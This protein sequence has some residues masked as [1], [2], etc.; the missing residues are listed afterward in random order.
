MKELDIFFESENIIGVDKPEGLPTTYRNV[1]DKS[2]CVTK[3]VAE[4]Y[5]ETVDKVNGHSDW[6]GGL[7]YR[8]DNDTSGIV[9]I[10]RNQKT[11][12]K[13]KKYQDEH[14]LA[15]YYYA[16]CEVVSNKPG[17]V[18][19]TEMELQSSDNDNT[20]ET[21][22]VSLQPGFSNYIGVD[23]K[24]IK[25]SYGTKQSFEV[26][27]FP[28]GHSRKNSSKMVAVLGD[29]Y[30]TRGN[31]RKAKTFYRIIKTSKGTAFVEAVITKGMRHQIRVHLDAVGLKI[32][33]DSL[34]NE[35]SNRPLSNSRMFLHCGRVCVLKECLKT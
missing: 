24:Q 1:Q 13:F 28:V 35:Y 10:A 7:L 9:L 11:F 26:V 34:Y 5:P 14:R 21:D 31:S 3:R 6:E 33:G 8:L 4:K 27:N 2:D 25:Y 23:D 17:R 22:F 32:I 30:K 16:L 19:P 12:D 15:K 18:R 29:N 20:L